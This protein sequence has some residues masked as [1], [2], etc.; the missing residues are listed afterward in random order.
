M[1]GLGWAGKVSW[2]A[3]LGFG[4]HFLTCGLMKLVISQ[5]FE[6]FEICLLYLRVS[7]SL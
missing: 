7:L 2:R 5:C 3:R 6:L 1:T 4:K